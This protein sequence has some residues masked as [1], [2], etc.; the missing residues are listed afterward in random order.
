M[1]QISSV[2]D[3]R[4]YITVT[5]IVFTIVA[6]AHFVRTVL[7]WPLVIGTWSAPMWLSWVALIIT[8]VLAAM[9]FRL[10]T[11]ARPSA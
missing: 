6:A 5:A 1:H 9:G 3:A 11:E 8:G 2:V 10:A 7:G 4:T